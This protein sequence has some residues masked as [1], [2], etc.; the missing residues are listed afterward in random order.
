MQRR[1]VNLYEGGSTCLRIVHP[2]AFQNIRVHA[3]RDATEPAKV[4]VPTMCAVIFS[5][6]RSTDMLPSAY[7]PDG[8]PSAA[9]AS[10]TRTTPAG[11][12]AKAMRMEELG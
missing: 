6:S 5:A 4:V 9:I 3:S 2:V 1:C 8:R 7:R 12:A 10:E 11:C